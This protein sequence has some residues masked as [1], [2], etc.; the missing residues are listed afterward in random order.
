MATTPLT[1]CEHMERLRKELNR[2]MLASKELKSE[3]QPLRQRFNKIGLRY[4]STRLIER[5]EVLDLEQ[6][7]EPYLQQILELEVARFCK[8]VN[9]DC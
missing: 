8:T 4:N 2:I 1:L 3:T 6:R 7:I 5:E 9:N